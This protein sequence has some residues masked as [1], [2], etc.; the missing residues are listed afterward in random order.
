[1]GQIDP[2]TACLPAFSTYKWLVKF[3]LGG[4]AKR[5]AAMPKDNMPALGYAE[6]GH[7]TQPPE[8][9][10]SSHKYGPLVGPPAADGSDR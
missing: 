3:T 9:V 6:L 7:V 2:K 1:M 10:A 5:S 4:K 8:L